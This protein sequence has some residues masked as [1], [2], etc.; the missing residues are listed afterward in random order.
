MGTSQASV[1]SIKARV[2]KRLKPGEIILMHLGE[3][4]HD[5]STL[6]ADALPALISMLQARG[7]SFVALTSMLPAH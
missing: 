1:S 2:L 7:Y 5:R 4:P 6:D 3:N